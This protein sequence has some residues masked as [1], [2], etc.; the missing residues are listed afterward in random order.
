MLKL[1]SDLLVRPLK[2][3]AAILCFH[4]ILPKS[5]IVSSLNPNIYGLCYSNYNFDN[6]IFWVS[7][8]YKVV[9]M[10][11]LIDHLDSNSKEFVV[12]ITFDDGYKDNLQYALPI[13][14]KYNVPAAIYVTKNFIEKDTL[15][16]WFELWE[17][18]EANTTLIFNYQSVAYSF[19]LINT[20]KKI[21]AFFSLKKLFLSVTTDQHIDLFKCMTN[22]ISYKSHKNIFLTHH[23][24]SYLA[25]HPLITIGAHTSNHENLRNLTLSD[26]YN[27]YLLNKNE[28]EIMLKCPIKHFAYPYGSSA[29][30]NNREYQTLRTV[31]YTSG[32]TLRSLFVSGENKMSLV[33]ISVTFDFNIKKL[34]TSF[35]IIR[36]RNNYYFQLIHFILKY[37]SKLISKQRLS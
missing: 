6:L 15:I 19:D 20:G 29:E 32:V 23:E 30:A 35:D 5:Q 8:N 10:D 1:V 33:R 24:L 31:G 11:D 37:V 9:S 12:S 34:K 21:I 17:I 7:K 14:E 27:E 36:N 22:S 3:K 25:N 13:L 18:I 28:L 2:G 4:R 16:W 26:L